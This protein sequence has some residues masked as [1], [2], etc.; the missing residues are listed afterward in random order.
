ME[1]NIVAIII[2]IVA[3]LP[4]SIALFMQR[5]KGNA[6]ATDII[7]DTAMSLI[8]PLRK[9]IAELRKELDDLRV[10]NV[11][12]R[13]WAEALSIE[14]SKYETPCPEPVIPKKQKIGD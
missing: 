3:I 6:E 7:T 8:E 12:L 5:K 2:A 4:G 9:E 11:L 14:V 13:R 10:E 1:N